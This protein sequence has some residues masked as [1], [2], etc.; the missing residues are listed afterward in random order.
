MRNRWSVLHGFLTW[1]ARH[2]EYD[3]AD[4]GDVCDPIIIRRVPRTYGRVQGANPARW[5]STAECERLIASC[6][7]GSPM[8]QR[9]EMVLRLGL[10]GMRAE[11]IRV[12]THGQIQP[13]GHIEWIGKSRKPRKITAGPAFLDAYQRFTA[14]CE[15]ILGRPASPDERI[16]CWAHGPSKR[17]N[18]AM[19]SRAT[20][21]IHRIVTTRAAAAGLGHVAP[22]DLRRTA[23]SRLHKATTDQG[24]HRFD[25][26]DIQRVLG[27]ADP[28]TTMRCYLEPMDTEP[29]DRAADYLD[30]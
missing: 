22:H 25:L 6:S 20:N 8:D 17:I 24:A 11:E 27:H 30:V 18:P 26:L 7:N 23:A 2:G 3:Q 10:L 9:D 29:I 5:L 1:C 4:I 16:C 14:T 21:L 28:A 13:D 12:L 15:A 19:P